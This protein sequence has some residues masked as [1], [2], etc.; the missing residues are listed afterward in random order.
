MYYPIVV[1][2]PCSVHLVDLS[3]P[4]WFFLLMHQLVQQTLRGLK[5]SCTN[6]QIANS[7]CLGACVIAHVHGSLASKGVR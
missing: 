4:I 5:I 3:R 2:P 1:L 6:V 7:L